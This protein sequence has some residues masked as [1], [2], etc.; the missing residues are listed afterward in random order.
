MTEFYTLLQDR[1][2][3]GIQVSMCSSDN[4]NKQIAPQKN[5]WGAGSFLTAKNMRNG[6][7]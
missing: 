2:W 4:W 3:E 5:N 1:L 7:F 6:Y